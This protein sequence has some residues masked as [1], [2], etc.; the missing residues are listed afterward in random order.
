MVVLTAEPRSDLTRLGGRSPGEVQWPPDIFPAL[1]GLVSAHVRRTDGGSIR[2][3]GCAAYAARVD[4]PDNPRA[5]SRR[6]TLPIKATMMLPMLM[7]VTPA[8]PK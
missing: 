5:M 3:T 8:C 2:S 7:P 1:A 6:I 4:I